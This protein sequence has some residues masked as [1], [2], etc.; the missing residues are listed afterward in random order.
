MENSAA[1]IKSASQVDDPVCGMRVTPEKS[2]HH[3]IVDG[4]T[5]WF[6]CSGCLNKFQS[7]PQKYLN[8]EIGAAADS[9][10]WSADT[11]F[12]CPMHPEVTQ[13]GAGECPSCGMALQPMNPMQSADV[14]NLELIDFLKRFKVGLVLGLPVLLLAMSP[15][16]G[17]PIDRIVSESISNWL[18]LLLSTP[19]VLWCG[20]PFLQRGL[21]SIK[22]RALNMFS[23][24]ALG[25][26]TAYL[27]S[28]ALVLFP[29]W[30]EQ[31]FGNAAT[32]SGVYFEVSSVIIV[33]VLIGQILELKGR[34][35]TGRAIRSLMKLMPRTAMKLTES[36]KLEEAELDE[37][38][39]G[40][41]LRVRPGE[42]VPLDGT[43]VSGTSDVN[44]SLLT[45][46]ALPIQKSV[47]DAVSAGTLNGSGTFDMEVER[48]AS[49]TTLSQIIHMVG[50]AQL[51]RA[52]IQRTADAVAAWFVPIVIAVA[53]FALL[54][55]LIWAPPGN[56][57]LALLAFVSVL[58]IAC[59]CALGLA[60]PMSITVGV[61]QAVLSGVLVKEA[62]ALETLPKIDTLIIDKTGTLT[63]GN[64]VVTRV[65]CQNMPQKTALAYAAAIA[66][67]SEHPLSAAIVSE[68][69]KQDAP[70]LTATE[71]EAVTGR[72]VM[73]MV[74]GWRVAAGNL[75][76]ME[77]L[78]IRNLQDAQQSEKVPQTLSTVVYLA[79]DGRYAAA[80]EV[81]DN[82]KPSSPA[83]VDSLKKRGIR[84]VMATGD[85]E[86]TAKAIAERCGI[87]RIYAEL[88]PLD[89]LELVQELQLKGGIV[90]M[91]GDGINDAPA[92]AQAD[93]GIA[94]GSGADVAMECAGITILSEDLEAIVRAHSVARA[95]MANVRQNLFFAFC[96]NAVGIP[97]A[98]GVL[99]PTFGILM[100]PMFAA[101]AMSLSSVSVIGNALRLRRFSVE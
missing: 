65:R 60:T 42:S 61:G 90:A 69:E 62:E 89:K 32:G 57:N 36:G 43:V 11:Q 85:R 75:S 70:V 99:Y 56:A 73:G 88:S 27:F 13:I 50:K 51:S 76:F 52:P 79:L 93:V 23:L 7:D 101:A 94:M 54:S 12:T 35:R 6:C 67:F 9:T 20:W 68:S 5:Y 100:S 91:A 83:T 8:P 87:S 48:V 53:F 31:V 82:I 3:C 92:L 81:S 47:G 63:T 19:I 30:S 16:L 14:P 41:R 86:D 64:P 59:P 55:W 21:K 29:S 58:I 40:D 1:E 71:F 97:V 84:I 66:R 26:S 78:E 34:E 44:E 72:G 2:R 77:S 46:E 74:N 80:I 18:Q 98:A 17:I 39:A 28:V 33:L 22:S 38:L 45:G 96:Y 49:Q 15:H 95:T 4:E 10:E 37:I 25:T 24:I